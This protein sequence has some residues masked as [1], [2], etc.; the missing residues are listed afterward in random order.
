MENEKIIETLNDWNFWKKD[1]NIG[2]YREKY[3]E[4]INKLLKT[5]QVIAI[6]GVRRSGKSTLMKQFIKKHIDSGAIENLFYI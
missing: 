6:T 5:E 2:V 4:K 3:L 1:L